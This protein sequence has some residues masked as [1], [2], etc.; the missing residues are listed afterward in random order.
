MRAGAPG[1]TVTHDWLISQVVSVTDG[2]TVRLHLVREAVESLDETWEQARTTRTHHPRGVAVRL[3]TLDTPERGDVGYVEARTD[4]ARWLLAHQENLRCQT[5]G[6][7]GWDRLLGDVYVTT[8]RGDTLTQHM[9]RQGWDPY[10][11]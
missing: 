3:V 1:V 8:D 6:S 5:Y 10:L 2:D 7:A 4:V 11:P 9:L